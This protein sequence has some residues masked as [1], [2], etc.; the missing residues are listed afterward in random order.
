MLLP[1]FCTLVSIFF[2]ILR[3]F[4]IF[5]VYRAAKLVSK[6]VFA[7]HPENLVSHLERSI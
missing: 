2:H 7:F 5:F 6:G 1:Q 3:F 4:I